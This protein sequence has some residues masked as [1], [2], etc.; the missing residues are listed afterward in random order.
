MQMKAIYV[1]QAKKTKACSKLTFSFC[2][3]YLTFSYFF[4]GE[5]GKGQSSSRESDISILR[6]LEAYLLSCSVID[7]KNIHSC[8]LI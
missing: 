6:Y 1:F 8:V 7:P 5:G 3:P 4:V 2:G